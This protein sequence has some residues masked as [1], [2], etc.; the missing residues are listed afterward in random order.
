MTLDPATT[1]ACLAEAR[2]YLL[3]TRSL[4][5]LDPLAV[6][7]TVLEAGVDLVQVRE[8]AMDDRSLL[9]WTHDLRERTAAHRVP[10]I[11][12]DRVDVALLAG[13]E[14]VHVGQQ[15]LPPL[16][17]RELAGEG[18]VVGL[19][20]HNLAQVT[21]AAQL[22]VDYIGIGPVFDTATKGVPGEGPELVASLIPH[23]TVPA[24]GVGG[25]DVETLPIAVEAGLERA[26]VSSAICASTEPAAVVQALLD[27]L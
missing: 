14:G 24:F 21:E 9:E 2:L 19:S 1:R 16:A 11:V 26:A 5:R 10:L 20:T 6:V 7:D 27:A 22:P 18:L 4:C 17:L 3:L 23:A 25:M 15:D 8:P 13:A 12:N